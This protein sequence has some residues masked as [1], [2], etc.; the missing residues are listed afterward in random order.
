MLNFLFRKRQA[1]ETGDR[2]RKAWDRVRDGSLRDAER[3]CEAALEADPGAA[4]WLHLLGAIRMQQGRH[5]DA[6]RLMEESLRVEP[7]SSDT[8]ADLGCAL[9]AAGRDHDALAAFDRVLGSGSETSVM[10]AGRGDALR[11]L[12]RYDEALTAYERAL[13]LDAGLVPALSGRG[14]ALRLLQRHDEALAS[15]AEAVARAPEDAEA[16]FRFGLAL[17]AAG[18]ALEAEAAF[19]AALVLRPDHVD[20]L[21]NRGSVRFA[22][23]NAAAAIADFDAVL[24]FAPDHA[25]AAYN[26]GVVLQAAGHV[27]EAIAAFDAALAIRP[28]HADALHNRGI[29]L[30]RR[31]RHREA[32]ASYR[33]LVAIAPGYPHALGNAA[34]EAAQLCE[35]RDR[36]ANVARIEQG[37]RQGSPVC[38]PF[39]FLALSDDPDDQRK[40]AATHAADRHPARGEPLWSG[41]RYG[42]RR[43]R[44][45][46]ISTDFHAHAVAYLTAGVFEQHDRDRFE[47]IGISLGPDVAGPVRSRL[48]A[49]F[50]R[51]VDARSMSDAECARLLREDDIDIAVD[52]AGF[53]GGG[54][55]GILAFRPAPAQVNYLGYPGTLGAGYY[56][57][58]LAD[59]HVIP[60]GAQAHY[61]ENVVWLPDSF[62]ANDS[63]RAIAERPPS[64]AEAGLP[65]DAFVYASF[66]AGYKIAPAMFDVWMR[67]LRRI[68]GSVL[69]LY[70]ANATVEA[71]LRSEAQARGVAPDRLVFAPKRP[72]AEYLAQYRLVDLF[73]DTLPFNGGT[74]ASDALWGGAPVLT[75]AGR[76]FAARMAA[77]LLPAV[78]LPELVTNTL[79]EYE[80]RAAALAGD[81]AWLTSVRETLARNRLT[82]P[83]FDTGRFTRHL[84]AAFAVMHDATQ[85]GEPP[86]AFAVA[87]SPA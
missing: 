56:D 28:G 42:H 65:D 63:K 36:D 40:C 22:L 38:L 10:H 52:L 29:A 58:I 49:S 44:V 1:G 60:D 74:T 79:D 87:R 61:A 6:I 67:L 62:Q 48:V 57:Y 7:A 34:N 14:D 4:A 13:S 35:W 27:D 2:L 15:H 59:R 20:A 77:S 30:G 21:L 73:L 26:R 43:I 5:A 12:G 68:D 78:G 85:R 86:R 23:G 72:Y 75:C 69:W 70:A 81:P 45:A 17:Q 53:T 9:L 64:R 71:N 25:G 3:L 8:R 54:R 16:S 82:A 11:A 46:Y 80:A 33:Q 55:P 76:S 47:V 39:I 24:M 31:G 18:R 32:L 84:E 19:D 50:D 37:V 41:Q 66:N 83:L 51:F